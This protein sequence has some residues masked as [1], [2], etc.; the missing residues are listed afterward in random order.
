MDNQPHFNE[1]ARLLAGLGPASAQDPYAQGRATVMWQQHAHVLDDL[2][3]KFEREY[4]SPFS[5]WA[6]IH[7]REFRA[8]PTVFYPFSGPDFMFAHLL[9][10]SAGTYL[11]G[12]LEICEAPTDACASTFWG[13]RLELLGELE[14]GIRHFLE[15]S[16]FVTAEMRHTFVTKRWNG[17]LAPLLVF[18]ARTGHEIVDVERLTVPQDQGS[19]RPGSSTTGAVCIRASFDGN[20]KQII[21]LQRHLRDDHCPASDAFYRFA[22]SFGPLGVFLKSA[23]YLLHEPDFMH[24]RDFIFGHA[25]CLV[26]DPSSMPYAALVERGWRVR[27][28]GRY[29]R[30]PRAFPQYE[31]RDLIR[32]CQKPGAVGPELPFGFGY[33]SQPGRASLMIAA[34]PVAAVITSNSTRPRTTALSAALC[35]CW[36]AGESA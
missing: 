16:F 33:H 28:H 17:I 25:A 10:P 4:A 35:P 11:L 27:V 15:H 7:L 32:L 12:G 22:G 13:S 14:A 20:P 36:E 8:L 30:T 21:Y 31:Q 1:L 9:H 6:R 26:Q 34:P 29:Q 19:Q 23:S 5:K 24:L 2:F 18:L 3:S